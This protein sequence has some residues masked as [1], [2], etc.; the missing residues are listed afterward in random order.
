MRTHTP[1]PTLTQRPQA[2]AGAG[3]VR[4]ERG[5][6]G[7]VQIRVVMTNDREPV[8]ADS[9]DHRLAASE[10]GR[11]KPRRRGPPSRRPQARVLPPR[12]A[13][14]G[15]RRPSPCG[16]V[17]SSAAS[18]SQAPFLLP[19]ISLRLPLPGTL[20]LGR[21]ARSRMTSSR[22][23]YLS[24]PCKDS[25]SRWHHI[26]RPGGHVSW[27]HHAAHASGTPRCH[28]PGNGLFLAMRLQTRGVR[29]ESGGQ[30]TKRL[31]GNARLTPAPIGAGDGV[32]SRERAWPRGLSDRDR[33]PD[34]RE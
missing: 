11:S 33:G 1:G 22:A 20:V 9:R 28:E 27:G 34:Q 18:S 7:G 10:A 5:R 15:S 4:A 19:T 8:A 21:G 13:S 12:P 2:L 16:R 32:R 14:R 30:V 6:L 23:P 17:A 29:S 31:H 24:D 26:P 25:F 3:S